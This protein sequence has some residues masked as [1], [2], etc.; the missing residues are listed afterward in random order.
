MWSIGVGLHRGGNIGRCYRLTGKVPP[1]L[2]S[3][4]GR[5]ILLPTENPLLTNFRTDKINGSLSLQPEP[6]DYLKH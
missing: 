2:A 5:P 1:R 3:L 6:I 4:T